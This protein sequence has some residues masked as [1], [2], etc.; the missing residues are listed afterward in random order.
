MHGEVMVMVV[1][2]LAA[3]FSANLLCNKGINARRHK[4]KTPSQAFLSL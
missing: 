2:V 3:Y 4:K 1:L